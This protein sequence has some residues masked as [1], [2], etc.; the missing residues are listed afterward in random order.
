M[1]ITPL[2]RERRP[3]A[4]EIRSIRVA[5]IDDDSG[6]VQVVSKH[7]QRVHAECTVLTPWTALDALALLRVN[8]AVVDLATIGPEPWRSLER[9]CGEL[10]RFG[11]VVCTGPCSVADRVRGLR[12]GASDWITKPC[13]PEEVVARVEATV[14]SRRSGATGDLAPLVTGEL[15]IRRDRF[16]VL[17][18]D[19]S[20]ELTRREFELVELLAGAEGRVI[21]RDEIYARVW[22]YSMAHGDRSVDVYVRK[23][24]AKLA[25]ISPGWRYVHTHFGVGYRFEAEPLDGRPPRTSAALPRLRRNVG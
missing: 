24:R 4:T 2:L 13:H 12:L 18:G 25:V 1:T 9:L 23:L 20:A 6:F 16:Q 11:V 8:A 19:V 22:G 3:V 21:E 17:A 10:G 5:L 7:L 15:A 14:R